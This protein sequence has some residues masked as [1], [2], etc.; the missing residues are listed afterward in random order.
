M[1]PY[2]ETRATE[3]LDHFLAAAGDLVEDFSQDTEA[4]AKGSKLLPI[5][6]WAA[7]HLRGVPRMPAER[8]ATERLDLGIITVLVPEARAV[9]ALLT[10]TGSH[11]KVTTPKGRTFH[12]GEIQA[13]DG[14]ALRAV[15]TRTL[16]PKA[17]SATVA[18]DDLVRTYR[19]RLM[20][21]LGIAGSI[22]EDVDLGD[23]V[24]ANQVIFYDDHKD[25]EGGPVRRGGTDPCPAP[26]RRRL[27]DFFETYGATPTF[28][29]Q[30]GAFKIHDGP[31]GTGSAV[32]GH[33][34]SEIRTWLKSFNDKTMAVETEASGVATPFYE[35]A[36]E[37]GIVGY[38][39]IRGIS[40]RADK[41]KDDRWHAVASINAAHSLEQLAPFLC[42]LLSSDG[43]D[44]H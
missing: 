33:E 16:T 3:V 40:D 25:T 14:R 31:V 22:H 43:Q 38:A 12:L 34:L 32:I 8:A 29:G 37:D 42:D 44:E 21:V 18:Y 36:A 13:G 24:I 28:N 1:H 30:D 17:V 10:K 5:G 27:A 19:P 4:P 20:I 26:V 39:V 23:V 2:D 9:T 41:D 7:S 11:R 6:N 35:R 15:A